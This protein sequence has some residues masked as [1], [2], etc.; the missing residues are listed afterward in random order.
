MLYPIV[1]IPRV[2]GQQSSLSL[3]STPQN[4]RM[5]PVLYNVDLIALVRPESWRAIDLFNV[6]GM[7][8]MDD[9]LFVHLMKRQRCF[10]EHQR[11]LLTFALY[12][13][14]HQMQTLRH[15]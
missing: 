7:A 4:A 2:T 8:S 9:S 1:Y 13:H 12:G 11:V 15:L 10:H 5:M 14:H 6:F 3:Q